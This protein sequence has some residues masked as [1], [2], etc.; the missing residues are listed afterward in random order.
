MGIPRT[1]MERGHECYHIVSLAESNSF[2]SVFF[3]VRDVAESFL[4]AQRADPAQIREAPA[5]R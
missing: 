2:F 1:V 5:R 4:D 3:T